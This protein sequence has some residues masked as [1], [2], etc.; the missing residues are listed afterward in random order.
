MDQDVIILSFTA[1]ILAFAGGLLFGLVLIGNLEPLFV[2]VNV[3]LAAVSLMISVWILKS[4][5]KLSEKQ[6]G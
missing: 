2:L 1:L 5:H 6:R 3:E 4:T